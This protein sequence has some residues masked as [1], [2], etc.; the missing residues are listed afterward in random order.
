MNL[1]TG[2]QGAVF[3]Q[4]QGASLIGTPA[5]FT[6]DGA[7]MGLIWLRD[8]STPVARLNVSVGGSP[9]SGIP[10]APGARLNV[11]F[12]SLTF[13]AGGVASSGLNGTASYVGFP[14]LAVA[15]FVVLT[16]AS[17]DYR[18]S[19]L[20]PAVTVPLELFF[21]STYVPGTL[22][23]IL[24]SPNVAGWRRLRL[25][26]GAGTVGCAFVVMPYVFDADG[27]QISIP[28]AA[29]PLVAGATGTPSSYFTQIIDLNS[30]TQFPG[31]G[32]P[33]ISSGVPVAGNA[34]L[35]F[36]VDQTAGPAQGT[37]SIQVDGLE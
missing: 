23:A 1:S 30:F 29:F 18:E 20:T 9:S 27:N 15:N 3:Y 25:T 16:D 4:L 34:R 37:I 10:M 22:P 12:K 36:E 24:T 7:G 14:S 21:T 35:G 11:R 19:E 33:G 6:R 8:G 26:V 13:S 28:N 5:T 17:A 31:L 32:S 2:A